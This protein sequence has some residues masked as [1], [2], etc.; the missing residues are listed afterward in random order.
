[1]KI[2]CDVHIA[3]KVVRFLQEQGIESVHVNDILESWYTKDSSIAQYADE[4]GFTVMSKDSDFKDSHFLKGTPRRLLK[5]SLGNI[6]TNR[7][8]EI[9][10]RNLE[11]L[12]EKFEME[13]CYVEINA[14][15][16]VIIEK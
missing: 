16:V 8:I 1:M 5:I 2:L 7:L 4:Q 13:K 9:L 14:D 3:R 15:T 12:K 6:S 10:G 11:L